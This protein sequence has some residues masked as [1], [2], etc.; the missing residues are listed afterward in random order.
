MA[1]SCVVTS[2][3]FRTGWPNAVEIGDVGGVAAARHHD[4]PDP[5]LIVPGV[6]GMPAPVE[7]DFEPGGKVHRRRIRGHADVAEIAGAVARRHV[8]GAAERR[9]E[10]GEIAADADAF[11]QPSDAVRR[12]FA[13]A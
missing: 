5:R 12:G 6:E 10:M 9:G 11:A 3:R 1:S 13:A 4:A 8:H 7:K 2:K